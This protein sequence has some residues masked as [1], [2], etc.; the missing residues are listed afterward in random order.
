LA[1]VYYPQRGKLRFPARV[2]VNSPG[3]SPGFCQN[4]LIPIE[5]QD[6]EWEV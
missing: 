6:G 4:R 3:I 5:A 2:K 1:A